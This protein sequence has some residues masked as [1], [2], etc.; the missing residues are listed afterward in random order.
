PDIRLLR[1]G[2]PRIAGQMLDLAPYQPVSSMPPVPRDLSV[3]VSGDDDEETLGDR[4]RDALGSDAGC[5]E[6]VR[7][8]PAS[9]YQ[10][11]RA[12]GYHR[13]WLLAE[14]GGRARYGDLVK[15]FLLLA[16]RADDAAA[17]NEYGSFLAFAQ[18]DERDLYRY[19][20]EQRPLGDIDLQDWSGIFLGGGP[21]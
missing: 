15:P 3:A 7:V 9:A 20:L 16:T 17:D 10:Q 11:L 13:N 12:A 2:D 5:D 4:V 1:S 6:E 18:L 19:R 21:F 8:L 14:R